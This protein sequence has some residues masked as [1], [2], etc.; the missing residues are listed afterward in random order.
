MFSILLKLHQLQLMD[1]KRTQANV[2]QNFL[3]H[4]SVSLIGASAI[5]KTGVL[6]SGVTQIGSCMYVPVLAAHS[7]G[8]TP[9]VKTTAQ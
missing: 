6:R 5:P 8:A 1:R 7:K 2:P 4:T 3:I 9:P